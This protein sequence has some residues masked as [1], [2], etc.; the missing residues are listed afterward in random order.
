MP[1]G[2]SPPPVGVSLNFSSLGDSFTYQQILQATS[3][4]NDAN[5]IKHSNSGDLFRG[6]LEGFIPIVIKKI[7]LLSS[8]K[9]E[10]YMLELN[11]FGKVSHSRL[12]PLLGDCLEN[13]KEKFLVDKY[14]PNGDLSS[15]LF[16]RSL[17]IHGHEVRED[18]VA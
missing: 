1:A 16:K 17:L 14:M 12:V 9:K 6:I 11:L 3:D 4:F 5:L 13:E 7:D 2:E 10:S 15:S 18:R 8:V